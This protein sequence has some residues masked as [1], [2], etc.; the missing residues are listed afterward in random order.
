MK[1]SIAF[2]LLSLLPA[3]VLATVPVYAQ[4]G[5][6]GYTGDTV[7]ASGSACVYQNDFY[8]QCVPGAATTAPPKTTSTVKATTTPAPTKTTGSASTPTGLTTTLPASSGSVSYPTAS[9]IS[10]SFDGGM[11][12]Y[13]RAGSS[14]ECQEQ[15][16]TGE[17]D[18]VFI[19]ES[20]AT[21]SNVIIGAKQAEGIH[22]RGPCT[23]KNIWWEDVCEDAATF[24]QTGSGDI[25][26]IIG[27]GAFNAED[28]I[29]QHNGAGTVSIT[30]FSANTFGKLYRA[31]GNCSTQYQRHV[32]INN[33][34]MKGGSSGVGINSNYGDTAKISKVCT[35]GKP[36]ATN[37]CCI[38]TGVTPGNEPPKIGCGA[39]GTYCQYS[40]SD[41]TTC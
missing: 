7:C 19:L 15:T 17:A 2:A 29:F 10:G 12:K 24:K 37:V 20:G 21:I 38:Y 41:V 16:E 13:D 1:S 33:V 34:A 36:S 22:C 32:I 27:G 14:G 31:C 6:S 30:N 5:G 40:T 28:K 4:C 18:A 9:V 35:N 3:T 23:L 11:K 8:S 26:Y 25:S 39:D